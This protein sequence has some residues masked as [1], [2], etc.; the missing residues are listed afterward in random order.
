MNVLAR[1]NVIF[2]AKK[3]MNG[4]LKRLSLLTAHIVFC[5]GLVTFFGRYCM[6]RPAAYLH[7]YKEYLSGIAVL[8]VIYS[9]KL[10][11]FPKLYVKAKFS[12]YIL[13]TAL[14]VLLAFL[15]EMALVAPDISAQ[16]SSQF[17]SHNWLPYLAMDGFLVLLRDIAFALATFSVLAFLYYRNLSRDKDS[18]LLKEFHRIEAGTFDKNNKK[19]LI[20]LDDISY[21]KQERNYTRI[22]LSN[23]QSYFRYGTLK[24]F[25]TLLNKSY[26]VQVSRSV[27]IPYSNVVS[28]NTSGVVV[29]SNPENTIISFS[30]NLAA[31]AFELLSQH[32]QKPNNRPLL[33]STPKKRVTK[34]KTSKNRKLQQSEII[35]AYIAEHP[36]C[37]AVEIKK[38]RSLSQSTVNRILKQLKDEHRI[39]Y[40]GS[41]KT[42]GYHTLPAKDIQ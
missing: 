18:N 6:L 39:E 19:M 30:D 10:L 22:F 27:V 25:T 36:D 15:F 33:P 38:N 16:T 40:T 35:Y 4:K 41:K 28:F 9:N 7:V 1:K 29:K 31:N 5:V 11:L 23:G 26:A 13:F 42:G 32:A 2:A 17:P 14:S 37:S 24:D 8:F 34:S 21:C 3:S 20:S 12:K